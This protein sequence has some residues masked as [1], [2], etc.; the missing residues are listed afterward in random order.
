MPLHGQR[1]G[2]PGQFHGLDTAVGGPRRHRQAFA[3]AVEGLVVVVGRFQRCG[4]GDLRQRAARVDLDRD[5]PV[6]AGCGRVPG[7]TDDVGQVLV[8]AP[9][10]VDV[11]DLHSPAD[12]QEGQTAI[13]GGADEREFGLVAEVADIAGL[14]VGG[15]AVAGRIDVAAAGDDQA[16]EDV[17]EGRRRAGGRQDHGLPAGRRHTVHIGLRKEAGGHVPGGEAGALHIAGDADDGTGHSGVT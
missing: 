12:A 16:V 2:V 3:E 10:E 11:E 13:E 1:E 7:V 15:F 9:A 6:L 14:G 5:P 4:P 17:H 8:Q